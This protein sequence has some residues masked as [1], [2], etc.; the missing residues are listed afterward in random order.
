M[1]TILLKVWLGEPVA[2]WLWP[3]HIPA[4][5][6]PASFSGNKHAITSNKLQR[7]WFSHQQGSGLRNCKDASKNCVVLYSQKLYIWV[8]CC[9]SC[10]TKSLDCSYKCLIK[11]FLWRIGNQLFLIMFYL[12]CISLFL[13]WFLLMEVGTWITASTRLSLWDP[14]GKIETRLPTNG[15]SCLQM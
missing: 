6:C 5:Y 3:H 10:L 15:C 11:N 7:I 8:G 1:I 4:W 14:S 13:R 9:M 12:K 2:W